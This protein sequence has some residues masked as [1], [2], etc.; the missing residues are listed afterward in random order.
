MSLRVGELAPQVSI[1]F[2]N[3]GPVSLRVL[4]TGVLVLKILDL[5]DEVVVSLHL[6]VEPRPQLYI[7]RAER[8]LLLAAVEILLPGPLELAGGHKVPGVVPAVMVGSPVA[9]LIVV[10]AGVVA[11]QVMD[12]LLVDILDLFERLPVHALLARH[13]LNSLID[14]LPGFGEPAA[15][16][17][18]R[19]VFEL[20]RG[21][22]EESVG[23][24]F[25][26]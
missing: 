4:E 18:R 7:F 24:V 15:V 3:V 6:L 8:A 1:F 12:D 19:E 22:V 21:F 23:V 11:G 9:S 26:L 5:L 17:G 2:G 13:Q 25:V 16:S 14:A 20:G 10:L